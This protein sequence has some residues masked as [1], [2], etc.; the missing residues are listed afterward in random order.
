MRPAP[1][2]LST[3][4]AVLGCAA[5]ALAQNN[6]QQPRQQQQQQSQGGQPIDNRVNRE[7]YGND[8]PTNV[9]LYGPQF[10]PLPS[11]TLIATQRS[12]ALPSEIRAQ[13]DAIGPLAPNGA[14]SYIPSESAL[15][16]ASRVRPP[17]LWGPAYAGRSSPMQT[18]TASPIPAPS[19]QQDVIPGE[20]RLDAPP[21]PP[22][23]Q[24]IQPQMVQ[25]RQTSYRL[26][27]R[28][29]QEETTTYRILPRTRPLATQPSTTQPTPSLGDFQR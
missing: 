28:P 12:G 1:V 23:P 26:G 27:D 19:V 25:P 9:P 29:Q 10:E 17:T 11:E 22:S 15:Q 4:A 21:P 20:R 7:L 16:R 3:V 8:R 6:P 13:Q 2:P 24:Y 14:A 5:M 18:G